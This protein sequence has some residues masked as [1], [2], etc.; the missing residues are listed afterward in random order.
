MDFAQRLQ[1]LEA[2]VDRG[3]R[4]LENVLLTQREVV[5]T[6]FAQVNL[7]LLEQH[8]AIAQHGE[9]TRASLHDLADLH[10]DTA[11]EIESLR[12]DTEDL[13]RRV[14]RLENPPAA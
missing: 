14:E 7:A 4:H 2:Q 5:Q 10:R 8:L 13:K 3:Y 12:Q 11:S 6:A 1:R 9:T